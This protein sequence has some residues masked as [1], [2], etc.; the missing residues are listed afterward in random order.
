MEKIFGFDK[1]TVI[2]KELTKKFEEVNRGILGDLVQ[3]FS[4]LKNIKGE[5]VILLENIC[6]RE[7]SDKEIISELLSQ[8]KTKSVKSSVSLIS[9]KL[10]ISR[11]KVYDIALTL[12]TK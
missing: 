9:K 10:E 1:K 6:K 11:K 5:F 3:S 7:I 8:L 2:C 12:K 4:M